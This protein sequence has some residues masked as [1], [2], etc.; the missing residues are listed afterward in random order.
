[1]IARIKWELHTFSTHVPIIS[2]ISREII[3]VSVL[4]DI[5]IY[6]KCGIVRIFDP[7]SIG[8]N[9]RFYS[10]IMS[11]TLLNANDDCRNSPNKYVTLI[12]SNANS[13]YKQC[14]VDTDSM[15]MIE[16]SF[17]EPFELS[18][19]RFQKFRK[20]AMPYAVEMF[21]LTRMLSPSLSLSL[22]SSLTMKHPNSINLIENLLVLCCHRSFGQVVLRLQNSMFYYHFDLHH[23]KEFCCAVNNYY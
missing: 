18:G 14:T 10:K 12:L 16:N 8:V 17:L 9:N 20:F 19:R 22:S 5:R 6:N 7:K 3:F 23:S 15:K 21:T 13:S 4:N 11:L 1:M 2:D